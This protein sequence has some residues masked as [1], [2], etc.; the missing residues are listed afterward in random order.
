MTTICEKAFIV[1]R[2]DFAK[3]GV[4]FGGGCESVRAAHNCRLG[5]DLAD[6]D[7]KPRLPLGGNIYRG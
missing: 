7:V 2:H 6:V 1:K 3:L 4:F 5:T